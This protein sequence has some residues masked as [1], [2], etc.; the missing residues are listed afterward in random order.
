MGCLLLNLPSFLHRVRLTVL[1]V[2]YFFLCHDKKWKK[3]QDPEACFG[4]VTASEQAKADA[5]YETRT[6]VFVRHGES[7]WN[8]NAT[9]TGW[10]DV[11]LS[12]RGEREVGP[13]AQ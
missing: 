10:T 6:V 2:A 1:G 12:E 7:T 11:D 8:R 5:K 3:P 9:F 4:Q 13:L